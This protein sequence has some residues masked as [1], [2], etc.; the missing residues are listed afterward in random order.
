MP[1]FHCGYLSVRLQFV[2]LY[3]LSICRLTSCILP[4]SYLD[5]NQLDSVTSS[6]LRHLRALKRLD[7]S[8]NGIMAVENGTFAQLESL[9]TL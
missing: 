3:I 2:Q 8:N 4:A 1:A 9:E 6:E 7:L 5:N